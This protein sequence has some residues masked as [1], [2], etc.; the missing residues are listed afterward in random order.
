MEK[1]SKIS[2]SAFQFV[3]KNNSLEK[4]TFEEY[5]DYDLLINRT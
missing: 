3:E 4:M 2:K 5:K 1:L